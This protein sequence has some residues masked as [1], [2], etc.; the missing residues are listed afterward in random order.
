VRFRWTRL[1]SGSPRWEQA[2]SD[3]GGKSWEINWT[4]DFPKPPETTCCPVVELRQYTLKPGERDTLIELFEREFIESQEE[5][6]MR[7]IGT[8]RDLEDPD[9]F[10]WLRGFQDM[11]SRAAQLQRFYGGPVWKAHREAAN[12]TM[13][14]SDNVLLLRPATVGSGFSLSG[15]RPPRGAAINSPSVI[16]ATICHLE[17]AA[18]ADFVELFQTTI[19][20]ALAKIPIP[21]LGAFITEHHQNTFPAL[22]VH[23]DVNVF[24]WFCRFPDR[25]AYE[26]QASRAVDQIAAKCANRIKGKPEVLFLAPTARSLL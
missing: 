14:D 16:V 17:N 25:T 18:E 7:V 4:M 5:I 3:D 11:D 21:I 24:V 15:S 9:R 26:A 22:P 13:I 12:A 23:E 10:V 1:T 20:P 19:A 6:G 8:F 2:F